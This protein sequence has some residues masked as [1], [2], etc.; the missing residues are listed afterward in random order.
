M[1]S[2]VP[3]MKAPAVLEWL[4]PLGYIGG[5]TVSRDRLRRLRPH[6]E[7]EPFLTLDFAPGAAA[8]VD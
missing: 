8:Q 4:R 2:D 7:R 3:E 5:I 6:A 1:L